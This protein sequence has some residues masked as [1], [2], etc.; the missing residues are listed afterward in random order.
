M[1]P[2]ENQISPV[3]DQLRK[4]LASAPWARVGLGLPVV[5]TLLHVAVSFTYTLIGVIKSRP[6]LAFSHK[7]LVIPWLLR[8][9]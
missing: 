4:M 2:P 9:S 5:C 3:A 7:R 6:S 1:F 8:K